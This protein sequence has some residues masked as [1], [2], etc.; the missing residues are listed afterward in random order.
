MNILLVGTDVTYLAPIAGRPSGEGFDVI[1][2]AARKGIATALETE[3][4]AHVLRDLSPTGDLPLCVPGFAEYAG[5]LLFLSELRLTEESFGGLKPVEVANRP[6]DLD[7]VV[8]R[9]HELEGA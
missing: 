6:L 5:P 9:I 2:T 1:V 4:I 7:A 3:E 8:Q